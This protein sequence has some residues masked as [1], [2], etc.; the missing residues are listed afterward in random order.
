MRV[1]YQL[2]D[3]GAGRRQHDIMTDIAAGYDRDQAKALAQYFADKPWPE[4]QPPPMQEGDAA[5]AEKGITGGQCRN[6]PTTAKAATTSRA[7]MTYFMGS[8]FVFCQV[9]GIRQATLIIQDL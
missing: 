8:S 9:T 6:S 2:R 5:A 7:Y 3:Y 1:A 4:I